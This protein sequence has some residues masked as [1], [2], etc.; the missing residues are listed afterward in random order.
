MEYLAPE[1]ILEKKI[2]KTTDWWTFGIIMYELLHGFTPFYDQRKSV[3]VQNIIGKDI[4]PYYRDDV[5]P[6]AKS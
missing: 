3:M 2:D 1:T 4:E 5:S 6:A